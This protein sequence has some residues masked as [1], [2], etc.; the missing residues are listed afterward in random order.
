VESLEAR[1]FFQDEEKNGSAEG[2]KQI[3]DAESGV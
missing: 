2:K 1:G 3:D